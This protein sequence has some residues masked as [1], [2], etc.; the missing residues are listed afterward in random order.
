MKLTPCNNTHTKY[1]FVQTLWPRRKR[2]E[3]GNLERLLL[4]LST[5]RGTFLPHSFPLHGRQS[6]KTARFLRGGIPRNRVIV[7]PSA[8][9]MVTW[10]QCS[11][12]SPMGPDGTAL[13]SVGTRYITE[14][15]LQ[16]SDTR[17]SMQLP[18]TNTRS[19]LFS[20][21]CSSLRSHWAG[22]HIDDSPARI[23]KLAAY[24]E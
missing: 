6:H 4:C 2:G 10:W 9:T 14:L 18:Y 1:L 8:P 3:F 11:C 17:S 15:L 12:T 7:L 5:C 24:I 20:S 13:T 19:V 22:S 23:V 21:Q 16:R